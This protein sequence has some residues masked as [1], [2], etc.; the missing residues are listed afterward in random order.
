MKPSMRT[1]M[2]RPALIVIGILS[3][4]PVLGAPSQLSGSAIVLGTD[5]AAYPVAKA[6]VLVDP[7]RSLTIEQVR[8]LER[9]NAAEW[10]ETDRMNF[11]YSR[12]RFWM[13]IPVSNNAADNP[14]WLL[15]FGYPMIQVVHFH[16]VTGG[17]EVVTH[18]TGRLLPFKDRPVAY[19]T[20]LFNFTV[21]KGKQS[22]L[23]VMV[24]S[25]GT[26]FAPM[27]IY[28]RDAFLSQS[29]KKTTAI[30]I[31]GGI[32]LAMVLTNVFLFLSI[33]DR[34]YLFYIG[35]A[36]MFGLLMNSLNGITYQYL[37]PDWVQWNKVSVPVL[38][39][40]CYLFLALFTRS[41]L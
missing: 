33:R 26:V 38:A 20:F 25:L 22:D 36:M 41:F 11:G 31:Y 1:A 21:P 10:R 32:M 7:S 24:E 27:A 14:D 35:Y 28:P 12:S 2:I 29:I 4:A 8:E 13:K 34:N 37:W 5:R 9:T 6:Q 19:R 15:E 40:L 18:E 16:Q 30:G 17:K 3:A 39:G 23:Y